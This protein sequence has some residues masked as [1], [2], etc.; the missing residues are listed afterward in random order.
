MNFVELRYI[1]RMVIS[2]QALYYLNVTPLTDVELATLDNKMD[3][4]WK[5]SIGTIP[6]ASTPLCFSSF[7]SNFPNLVEARRSL[8]IRQAS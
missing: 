6:G 1:I 7:G 2:S 5:R 8:L 3:L 4:L